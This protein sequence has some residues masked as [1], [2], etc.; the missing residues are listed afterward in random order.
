MKPSREMTS[1]EV[2]AWR[3]AEARRMGL[4]AYPPTS[5][6][7]DQTDVDLHGAKIAAGHNP[8]GVTVV[9][10]GA[11]WRLLA[12]E[13]ICGARART[14]KTPYRKNIQAWE[15]GREAGRW[16]GRWDTSGWTGDSEHHT[17]RTA[18]PPGFFLPTWVDEKV[19]EAVAAVGAA[20]A[21]AP[22]ARQYVHPFVCNACSRTC[23]ME[24]VSASPLFSTLPSDMLCPFRLPGFTAIWKAG[25]V[26]TLT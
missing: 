8:A 10:V 6:L 25:P 23:T 22:D 15:A 14:I 12:P 3:D 18:K 24:T 1:T 16:A 9:Q 17:Y 19:R 21:P 11:G 20:A 4:R 2:A 26:Q 5:G 7:Y 13:E